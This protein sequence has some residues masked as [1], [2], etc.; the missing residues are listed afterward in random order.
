MLRRLI[1]DDSNS[2]ASAE[3]V[4]LALLLSRLAGQPGVFVVCFWLKGLRAGLVFGLEVVHA[5]AMAVLVLGIVDAE[6]TSVLSLVWFSM[7]V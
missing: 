4:Q 7:T 5:L 2:T 1:L 6:V 3:G